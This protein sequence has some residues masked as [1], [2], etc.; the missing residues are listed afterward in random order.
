MT[1]PEELKQA[2]QAFG[3]SLRAAPAVQAYLNAQQALMADADARD[4]DERTQKMY[5]NLV[6]RQQAGEQLPRADVDA[7]Y[8][9]NGQARAHPLIAERDAALQMVKDYFV[10]VG[11]DLSIAVGLDYTDLAID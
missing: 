3:Q 9:L 2:A 7:F 1:L 8:A 11:Q 5:E 6:A 4:L 10:N